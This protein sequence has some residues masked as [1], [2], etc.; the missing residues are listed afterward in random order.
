M[1]DRTI[2]EAEVIREG[3]FGDTRVEVKFVGS[4]KFEKLFSFY[5]DEISFSSSEF[6]GKTETEA[7]TLK[8]NKDLAFIKS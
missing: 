7:N 5:P 8:F 4:D 2:V 6:I 1:S 3:M